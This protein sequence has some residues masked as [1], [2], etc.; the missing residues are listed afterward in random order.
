LVLRWNVLFLNDRKSVRLRKNR[1]IFMR[2][3]K[4]VEC[5]NEELS[6]TTAIRDGAMHIIRNIVCLSLSSSDTDRKETKVRLY[7]E[8]SLKIGFT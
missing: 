5:V 7:N 2:K 6:D 1:Y 4:S 8:D 3:R